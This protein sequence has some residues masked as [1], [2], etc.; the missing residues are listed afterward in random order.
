MSQFDLYSATD[1]NMRFQAIYLALP[2]SKITYI[3]G[4]IS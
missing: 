4:I 1:A 2:D 3:N